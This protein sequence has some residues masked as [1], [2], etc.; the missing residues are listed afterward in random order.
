M[1][2]KRNNRG[3]GHVEMIL[4]SVLFVGALIFLFIF[5][6]PFAK[7]DDIVIIDGIQSK[8]M[9]EISLEVGKLSVIV[10]GND[11]CYS[12]AEGIHPGNYVEVQDTDLRRYSIYFG[13]IFNNATTNRISGC[14]TGFTLG[15]YSKETI[16]AKSKI[17]D[18]VNN[19]TSNYEVLKNTMGITD[20]FTFSF[21]NM[22][23][24][25]EAGLVTSGQNPIG[26]NIE[27]KEFPIRVMH[28]D[29]TIEDLILN[30]RAWK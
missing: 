28:D 2:M 29:G 6:N 5:I 21:K 27:A 24:V 23:G 10:A 17:E 22:L 30:I 4:S 8:I 16:I 9:D 11:G 25:D 7:T 15:L 26:G 12:F 19:Y 18:M 13:E 1:T 14:G 3:Q 20:E